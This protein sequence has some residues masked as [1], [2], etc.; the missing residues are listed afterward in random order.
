MWVLDLQT[1]EGMYVPVDGSADYQLNGLHQIKVCPLF[2]PFL[3]WLYDQDLTRLEE[4][5][6]G[7]VTLTQEEAP[8]SLVA[9]RRTAYAAE[10]P[11]S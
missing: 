2:E 1:A 8:S 4:L 11:L 5:S 9:R 7:L 6:G 3:H 10:S